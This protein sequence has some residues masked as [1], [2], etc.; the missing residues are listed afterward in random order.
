ML[1]ISTEWA[2]AVSLIVSLMYCFASLRVILPSLT[3]WISTVLS[4]TPVWDLRFARFMFVRSSLFTCNL[5]LPESFCPSTFLFL[6][7][8]KIK[9]WPF[10]C[11]ALSTPSPSKISIFEI[12]VFDISV[13]VWLVPPELLSKARV[14]LPALP[15]I[16]SIFAPFFTRIISSPAPAFSFL[17]SAS[18]S[19]IT[20]SSPFPASSS[21]TLPFIFIVSLPSPAF[22][23][24]RL[25]PFSM[26]IISLPLSVSKLANLPSFSV[27]L[28]LFAEPV[29]FT[30][31]ANTSTSSMP[32]LPKFLSFRLIWLS[33]AFCM[34]MV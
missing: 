21:L 2:F 28:S 17:T 16:S 8:P 32:S 19:T 3:S 26:F 22:R 18:F 30:L 5:A 4:L 10:I 20:S 15:S 13:G 9:L 27:I 29:T 6:S 33:F 24:A 23:L 7:P 12:V 1:E 31:L 11:L 25:A 34:F 14:S